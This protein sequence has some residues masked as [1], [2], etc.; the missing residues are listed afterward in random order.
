[1]MTQTDPQTGPAAP[2]AE[3]H[4]QPP[5]ALWSVAP[6]RAE[7]RP[8]Q[9]GE[10]VALEML[11]SGISRGTE[12]LVH[13]GA[14]PASEHARMRAPFQEGSFAFP[15]KYGYS[16]VA[17]VVEGP[18]RGQVVFALHPHQT[19]FR[20]PEGNVVPLPAAL[21]PARA[22]LGANMETALNIVW[23]SRAMAGDRIAV[24]GAGV[25]GALVAYLCA[26][27][28]GS[29]VTLSDI[30]PA[31]AGLASALGAR[32]APPEALPAAQDV[33]IHASASAAGLQRAFEIA[34]P[35]ARIIEASWHGDAAV[36]L[37]LG[38]AFHSRR[39]QLVSSQVGAL[40]PAQA[41]RWT[42]RR[43]LSKAL[44]LLCDPRLDALISGETAFSEIAPVYTGILTAPETLCHRIR[45]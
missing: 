21:P 40:P 4:G 18:A 39:L 10:G 7:L 29:E 28:P 11:F 1:M 37:P 19:R 30:N 32:F 25:V 26:R 17:R 27:L 44:E 42:F 38:G 23:D 12:R 41:A 13:Q 8:A 34:A 20:L 3:A 45:Y 43:R 15:V 31:R 22:I 35:E 14:V 5:R 9:E 24:L 6:S 36:P 33:V 2:V 16:A